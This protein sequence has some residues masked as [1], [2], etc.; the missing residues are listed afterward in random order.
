VSHSTATGVRE[1]DLSDVRPSGAR[2]PQRNWSSRQVEIFDQLQELFLEEGFRHLTI[3]DLV[4]RLHCSR[5]TLYSLAPSREELALIVIDRLLNRMGAEARMRAE[6][7]DDPGDAIAAYLDTG[8]TT[9][10]RAQPAFT[11]DLESYVPTKHLYDRHL[12][13]ALDTLG[14][15]VEDGIAKGTFRSYHPPLVAEILDAA[16]D[17]IRRPEVLARAGVSMSQALAELSELIRRG[18]VRE[19]DRGAGRGAKRFSRS[20]PPVRR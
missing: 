9:L 6:A 12:T 13:N 14:K 1:V 8:V 7:C 4:D 18:L 10:R 16:V 17:R 2:V 3:A 11:E 5:R 20:R 15:L 19:P